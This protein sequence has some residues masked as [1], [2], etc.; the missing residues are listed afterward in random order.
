MSLKIDRFE[1]EGYEDKYDTI[2]VS[3]TTTAFIVDRSIGKVVC[4]VQLCNKKSKNNELANRI[5]A[6]IEDFIVENE[7]GEN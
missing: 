6:T 2:K 5:I 4:F 3:N 7:N 1:V